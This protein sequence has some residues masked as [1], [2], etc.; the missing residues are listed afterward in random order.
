MFEKHCESFWILP[1][2]KVNLCLK[3]PTPS[4]GRLLNFGVLYLSY[5]YTNFNH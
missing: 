2:E 5:V 1:S 4:L 3:A